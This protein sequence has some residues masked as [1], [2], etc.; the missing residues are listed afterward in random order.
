MLCR[1]DLVH[2]L[3][4]V[5]RDVKSVKADLLVCSFDCLPY[6]VDRGLPHIH[7]DRSDGL[8]PVLVLFKPLFERCLHPVIQDFN[9]RSGVP[10]HQHRYVFMAL[11]KRRLIDCQVLN[12]SSLSSRQTPLDPTPKIPEGFP[13]PRPSHE[14]VIFSNS[15]VNSSLGSAHGT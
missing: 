14:I 10:I 1:S 8:Q 15:E 5:G 11:L 2:R 3:S 12:G 4:N 9:D 6:C 13:W 7:R